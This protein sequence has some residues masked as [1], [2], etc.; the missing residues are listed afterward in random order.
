MSILLYFNTYPLLNH[1]ET[2]SE[3]APFCR[4][5]SMG[6]QA[7]LRIHRSIIP[8][9]WYYPGF[10][11]KQ[12][13]TSEGK[14]VTN[15]SGIGSSPRF[16]SH[17]YLSRCPRQRDRTV[18]QTGSSKAWRRTPHCSGSC[19]ACISFAYVCAICADYLKNILHLIVSNISTFSDFGSGWG[20]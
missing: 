12:S 5:A 13:V 9:P 19:G 1:L 16:S 18:I 20:S 15:N 2:K 3:F 10:S 14:I 4:P 7:R 8:E 6:R 17:Y 11:I